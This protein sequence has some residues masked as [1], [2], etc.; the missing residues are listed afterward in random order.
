MITIEVEY[1]TPNLTV[2]FV[3]I[4]CLSNIDT[5]IRPYRLW[6]K[7]YSVIKTVIEKSC[8][9]PDTITANEN[10]Q[11]DHCVTDTCHSS[12]HGAYHRFN[13]LQTFHRASRSSYYHTSKNHESL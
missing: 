11:D 10:L 12:E 8:I 4:S 13:A 9:L 5:D 7:K 1:I 6:M 3:T 2:V